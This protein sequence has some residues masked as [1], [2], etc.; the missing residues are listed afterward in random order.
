MADGGCAHEEVCGCEVLNV[1]CS[2]K[3][4][5]YEKFEIPI[6]D[7]TNVERAFCNLKKVFRYVQWLNDRIYVGVKSRSEKRLHTVV[8]DFR[9]G[10]VTCECRGYIFG[11]ECRHIKLVKRVAFGRGG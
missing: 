5:T 1:E 8:L 11:R 4:S 9:K 10:T 2:S 7:E 3:M 6:A